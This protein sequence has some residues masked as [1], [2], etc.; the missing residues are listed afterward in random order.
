MTGELGQGQVI[1][2]SSKFLWSINFMI[3]VKSQRNPSQISVSLYWCTRCHAWNTSTDTERCHCIITSS[4]LASLIGR[5]RE[6]FGV[7]PDYKDN[8]ERIF[9]A[10]HHYDN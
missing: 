9:H 3:F 8:I 6:E 2:Y 5:S 10:H 4:Q 1:P 7:V